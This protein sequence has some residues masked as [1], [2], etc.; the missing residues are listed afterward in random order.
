MLTFWLAF[1]LSVPPSPVA[2]AAPCPPP[3]AGTVKVL[4]RIERPS[5]RYTQG[6]IFRSGERLVESSGLRH[7]SALV[8]LQ[9]PRTGRKRA[10]EKILRTFENSPLFAEGLAEHAGKLYQLTWTE[11]QLF[12]YDLAGKLLREDRF[13]S[14]NGEGWGLTS[15]GKELILSD[16]SDDLTFVDPGPDSGGGWRELRRLIVRDEKGPVT[17]LNEL[18]Y[19]RGAVF[20]NVWYKN[21]V[22]EIDPVSGCVKRRYELGG[23]PTAAERAKLQSDDVLNGI[24]YDPAHDEFYVTGKRWPAIYRVKLR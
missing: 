19:A 10:K 23:L 4:S 12:V 13:T 17:Q 15:N 7:K 16:G 21:F 9:L 5:R 3:E 22:V 2:L 14:T 18:E 20:A 11:R 8:E 24:A 6:L 1:W